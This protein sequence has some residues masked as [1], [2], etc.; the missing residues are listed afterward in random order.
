[1]K[2][3]L[4]ETLPKVI[5]T[6]TK[7]MAGGGFVKSTKFLSTKIKDGIIGGR[8]EYEYKVTDMSL[9]ELGRKEINLAQ[10]EMPGLMELR[11]MYPKNLQ[12]LK[13]AK[14]SGSLHMTI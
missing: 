12:P 14:I 10:V 9:A 11:K 8:H 1:M 7:K 4:T 3:V 6:S 5:S 13:G 2:T